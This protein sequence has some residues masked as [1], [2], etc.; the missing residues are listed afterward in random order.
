MDKKR[1]AI[2]MSAQLLVFII[3]LGISFVLTAVIDSSIDDAYGFTKTANDIVTWA[4]IVVSALNTM[5]S[6]F[7][8][9]Q[10]HKKD[11]QGAN[12]Y[13]SSVFYA[14]L[15]MAGVFLVPAI[16]VVLFLNFFVSII[17]SVFGVTTYSLN[18]LELTSL[19]TI[20]SE[21]VRVSI[22]FVTYRFF[23]AHLWYVGL[24]SVAATVIVA[25][26]NRRF[27]RR[28]LPQIHIGFKYFRWQ[29]VRELISL[30]AGAG[31]VG[32]AGYGNCQCIYQRGGHEFPVHCQADSNHALLSYGN[33]GGGLYPQHYDCLC[34]RK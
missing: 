12:E 31:T 10:L 6:R 26:A 20:V 21:L 13:F 5:A 33:C 23:P 11:D 25:F 2:N 9:I 3:N 18:R 24:G 32:R 8:T 15:M 7:I 27:T 19:A 17:T 29:K 22:L 16:C 30:G 4:Q 1:L 14:N 28:L 34:Q